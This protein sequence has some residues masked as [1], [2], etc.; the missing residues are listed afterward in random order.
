MWESLPVMR[1][2]VFVLAILCLAFLC[3]ALATT[4]LITDGGFNAPGYT[5]PWYFGGNNGGTAGIQFDSGYVSM[6]NVANASEW[7]Y[8]AITFPTNLIGATLSLYNAT[9]SSDPNTDDQ[10]EIWLCQN[11][12]SLTFIQQLGT[13]V[14]GGPN[15]NTGLE[16]GST[17][18]IT[19]AGSNILSSYAGQ[20]VDLLFYVDRSRLMETSL[21]STFTGVSVVAGTTA[22]IP[23][24]DDFTNAAV[25]PSAELPMT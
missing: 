19:Y 9:V 10:F 17:N 12:A 3:P 15:V 1:R 24:N 16:F 25:I 23:A 2:R 8:Q 18:F 11:N 20:T 22:D 4:Q 6:G 7:V 13:T 21:P 14:T 5:P